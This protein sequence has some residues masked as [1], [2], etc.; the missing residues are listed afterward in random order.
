MLS[1]KLI[2]SIAP[3]ARVTENSSILI[4]N[5][6]SN[7]HECK[8]ISWNLTTSL[9]DHLPQFLLL[10]EFLSNIKSCNELPKL[11]RIFKKFNETA[12]V[13]GVREVNYTVTTQTDTETEIQKLSA[14]NKQPTR[15][16]RSFGKVN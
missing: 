3:P 11:K 12:F 2:P 14:Y 4:D 8:T 16:T 7:I 1:N 6:L 15:Q 5:K 9:S 13:K 10:D